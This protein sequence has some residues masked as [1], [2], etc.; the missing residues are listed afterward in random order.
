MSLKDQ[1]KMSEFCPMHTTIQSFV[2]A[3]LQ[4]SETDR[5]EI[6]HRLLDSLPDDFPGI[7]VADPGFLEEVERR[8]QE[9]MK[10]TPWRT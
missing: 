2:D 7:A 9:P 8:A 1:A 3:A 5:L 6:A 4:F 10:G